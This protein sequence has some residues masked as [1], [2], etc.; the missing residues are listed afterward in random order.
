METYFVEG[1]GQQYFVK[2]G[3]Q[4]ERHLTMAEI[5]LTPPLL[6]YG[7]LDDGVSIIVQRFIRGRTPS[8]TDFRDQ[9]EKVAELV[10]QMHSQPNVQSTLPPAASNSYKEA[11]VRALHHLRQKWVRYRS[12]LPGVAAFIDANLEEIALQ[13]DQFSGEGLVASHNDICNANWLFTSNGSIYIVD[14][15]SMAMDDPAFDSGA[16]L[17]WYYPPELR[18]PFLQIAGYPDDEQF[19]FRMRIRMALH[20]LSITL[21][22]EQ[23]FDSFRPD[24]YA[25]ALEDFKA[26]LAGKENPQG[27]TE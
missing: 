17:W 16:L 20:C 19:R 26:V 3:A 22:R 14:L 25:A 6:A 13:I 12:Q 5:G 18:Q 9:L 2:V 11:G 4:I 8:R 24:N 1:N 15:D 21:P 27:Y 7:H 10:R 23:S